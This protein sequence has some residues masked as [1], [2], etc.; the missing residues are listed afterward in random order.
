[1]TTGLREPLWSDFGNVQRLVTREDIDE[2][3]ASDVVLHFV[4][5]MHQRGDIDYEQALMLCVVMLSR[6]ARSLRDDL[7]RLYR[8][9]PF[10]VVE[11]CRSLTLTQ[12]VRRSGPSGGG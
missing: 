7:H 3:A 6:H 12:K 8:E 5:A 2:L 11:T 4:L 10:N 9:M 1:M